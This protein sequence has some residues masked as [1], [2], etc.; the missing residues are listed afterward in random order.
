MRFLVS[1]L[2]VLCAMAA[3]V[4]AQEQ[5][6]EVEIISRDGKWFLKPV[7]PRVAANVPAS[8]PSWWQ[9]PPSGF[10][11]QA[12]NPNSVDWEYNVRGNRTTQPP[13]YQQPQW[14]Q[15]LPPPLVIPPIGLGC[16]V[17]GGGFGGGGYGGFGGYSGGHRPAPPPCLLPQRPICHHCGR[18]RCGGECGGFVG[19][20]VFGLRAGLSVGGGR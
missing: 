6:Q 18:Q 14:Q 1:F 16:G 12:S 3:Q 13:I 7:A 20:Q 5:E 4:Q 2:V 10:G 9:A 8:T 17:H 15:C 11:G 19:V